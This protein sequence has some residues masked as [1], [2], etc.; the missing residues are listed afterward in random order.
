MNLTE[1]NVLKWLSRWRLKFTEIQGKVRWLLYFCFLWTFP[2]NKIGLYKIVSLLN[3]LLTLWGKEKKIINEKVYK[4]SFIINF[5][6]WIL[7]SKIKISRVG[8]SV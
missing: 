2:N 4:N 6:Y 1:Y 3:I 5:D 8:K 7:F